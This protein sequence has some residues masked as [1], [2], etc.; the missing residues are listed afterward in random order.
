ML[1]FCKFFCKN[2]NHV[3]SLVL[4]IC[5]FFIRTKN[6]LVD[7]YYLHFFADTK[8]SFVDVGCLHIFHKNVRTCWLRLVIYLVHKEH[9]FL[10]LS[11]FLSPQ[12]Y[13]HISIILQ[14]T[15]STPRSHFHLF[16]KLSLLQTL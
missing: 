1:A 8:D 6:S 5:I 14:Y 10:I 7:V 11:F 3:D 12:L 15:F 4:T 2:E 9:N 13:L 16:T